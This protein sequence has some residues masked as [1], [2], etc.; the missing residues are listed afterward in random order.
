MAAKKK[1]DGEIL[2]YKGKPLIRNENIIYY[3]DPADKFIIMLTV[4]NNE[5]INDLDVATDVTVTLQTNS[6]GGRGKEKIIKKVEREGLYRALDVA[7][8]WLE[9]AL[10]G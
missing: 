2:L 4:N 1:K 10:E 7:A 9:D 6:T 8:V 5:K 3:G